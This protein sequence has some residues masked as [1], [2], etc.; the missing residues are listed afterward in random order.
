VLARSAAL[1]STQNSLPSGWGQHGSAG[2]VGVAPVVEQTRPQAE[3]PVHLRLAPLLRL[4]AQAQ[5]VPSRRLLGSSGR[6]R[7]PIVA[8]DARRG[9]LDCSWLAPDGPAGRRAHQCRRWVARRPADDGRDQRQ[10]QVDHRSG[11]GGVGQ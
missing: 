2:A 5:P 10:N 1:R 11:T 7:K 9:I 4:Q 6:F 8:P 3:E